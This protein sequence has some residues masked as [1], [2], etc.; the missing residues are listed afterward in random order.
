MDQHYDYATRHETTGQ[1]FNLHSCNLIE[2]VI[3]FLDDI[4]PSQWMKFIH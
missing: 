3:I 2:I 1:M 4:I